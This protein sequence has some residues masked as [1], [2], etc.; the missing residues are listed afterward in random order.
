MAAGCPRS[1]R[2]DFVP[3]SMLN[4]VKHYHVLHERNMILHVE[5]EQV[6]RACRNRR[7]PA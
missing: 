3:L 2:D 7:G 6:P 5:T 4:N 1:R